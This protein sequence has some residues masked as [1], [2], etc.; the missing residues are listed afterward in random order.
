MADFASCAADVPVFTDSEFCAGFNGCGDVGIQPTASNLNGVLSELQRRLG[1][2]GGAAGQQLLARVNG[3]FAFNNITTVPGGTALTINQTTPS[4]RGELFLNPNDTLGPD[5]AAGGELTVMGYDMNQPG[6]QLGTGANVV[7]V[8]YIDRLAGVARSLRLRTIA[9][10]GEPQ[11]P[12]WFDPTGGAIS[13]KFNI[14]GTATFG[15]QIIIGDGAPF[16]QDVPAIKIKQGQPA[17]DFDDTT[18]PSSRNYRVRSINGDF[19][20]VDVAA[21]IVPLRI[22]TGKV[23]MDQLSTDIT[24]GGNNAPNVKIDV[25][26]GELKR[27]GYSKPTVAAPATNAATTQA[28]VNQLRAALINYGIVI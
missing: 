13:V 20:V 6:R 18:G 5:A 1:L 11:L 22:N 26:T 12:I 8:F 17:I 19:G 27:V 16:A 14:D 21:G 25:V 10:G 4:T 3:M 28:L 2:G 9:I 24:L 7:G 15:R 23:F